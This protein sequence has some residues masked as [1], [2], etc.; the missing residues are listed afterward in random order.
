MAQATV[1][2][3]GFIMK[4]TEKSGAAERLGVSI[5]IFFLRPVTLRCPGLA[6]TPG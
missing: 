3:K 2:L 5:S 4:T 6:N 1:A